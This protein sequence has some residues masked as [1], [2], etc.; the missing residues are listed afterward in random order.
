MTVSDPA[1]TRGE[2]DR[3]L[4]ADVQFDIVPSLRLEARLLRRHAVGAGR[5]ERNGVVAVIAGLRL[6]YRRRLRCSAR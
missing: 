4:V 2:V 5:E 6:R 1:P 3:E